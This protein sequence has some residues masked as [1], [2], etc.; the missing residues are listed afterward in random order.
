MTE[1][2]APLSGF[3]NLDKPAGWTSSDVVSKLRSTFQLRK[4]RIKIG[5]GGTLDPLATG[6]LPICMG[7]ATRLSEFL[8]GSDKTYLVSARLGVATDTYD[9]EGRITET[10]DY[11]S[12]TQSQVESAL[13]EFNGEFDQVPPMFSAIKR[14]GQPLYKLARQGKSVERAAR[15]VRLRSWELI[16]W[17]LPDFDMRIECGS[18]FYVRSLVH[19]VGKRVR[20]GSHMTSLRRERVGEFD[21][22]DSVSIQDLVAA[23]TDDLWARYLLK[24]DHVLNHLDALT[25]DTSNA[26]AFLHG[27]PVSVSGHHCYVD[28]EQVRVHAATGELL[29][30]AVYDHEIG[31]LHPAKVLATSIGID[32]LQPR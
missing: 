7:S 10:Q 32:S 29:G 30:L 11:R 20:C 31:Q 1:Y 16:S 12:I 23:A 21:I 26:S 22:A 13:S 27:R 15:R 2:V 18:G 28:A 24:P 6:V 4:R 25:L 14:D 8:L 19:D 5:H 3:L 17:K 9:S